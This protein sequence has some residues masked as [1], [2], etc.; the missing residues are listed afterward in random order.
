MPRSSSPPLSTS[1]LHLR[2]PQTDL[3]Q[4]T[5]SYTESTETFCGLPPL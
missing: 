3:P 1:L 4:L 5:R 2:L